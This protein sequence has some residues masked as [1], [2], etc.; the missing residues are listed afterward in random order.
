[1]FLLILNRQKFAAE[2]AK[3]KNMTKAQRILIV[4]MANAGLLTGF[5]VKTLAQDNT[6]DSSDMGT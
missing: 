4:T 5:S 1:M 3:S 2:S 6:N